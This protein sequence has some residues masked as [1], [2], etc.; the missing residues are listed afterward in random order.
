MRQVKTLDL[1]F[2]NFGEESL[3]LVKTSEMIIS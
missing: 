3:S 1:T 2:F